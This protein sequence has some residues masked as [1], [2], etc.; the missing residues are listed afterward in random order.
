M[1]RLPFLAPALLLLG[2]AVYLLPEHLA[3]AGLGTPAALAYMAYGL[4]STGA[5][6]LVLV[7][8]WRT[9]AVPVLLWLIYEAAAR[10]VCRSALSLHVPPPRDTTMCSA[11]FGHDTPSW[12]GLLIAALCSL[13]VWEVQ[14]NAAPADAA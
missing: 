3:A 4:E 11:A 12:V 6:L 8:L 7:L 10:W 14:K 2:A 13:I 9:P 1:K 5:W